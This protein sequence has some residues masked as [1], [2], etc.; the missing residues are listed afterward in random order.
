MTLSEFSEI[1]ALLAVQLG[2]TAADELKI[3]AFYEAL[4]DLDMELVAMAA[5]RLGR[6]R[7]N[8]DG[9]AWMPKAPEWRALAITIDA[10]RTERQRTYL[11]KRLAAG[12]D[13]LCL[14]CEDTGWAPIEGGRVKACE[15]RILRRLEV[16]GRRPVPELS[17][18]DVA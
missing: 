15:C 17:S 2:D 3:R 12:A 18:G 1:F 9:E 5:Q 10:E 4:R 11:R 8:A 7:L 6:A 13:P 16:L 14:A